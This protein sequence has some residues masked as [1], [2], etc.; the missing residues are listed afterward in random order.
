MLQNLAPIAAAALLSPLLLL[1]RPA[2]AQGNEFVAFAALNA[3]PPGSLVPI[4]IG[5]RVTGPWNVVMRYARVRYPRQVARH[6]G[7]LTLDYGIAGGRGAVTAGVN[8]CDG[9]DPLLNAAFDYERVISTSAQSGGE[10]TVSLKPAIGYGHVMGRE[11]FSILSASLG[12][13]IGLRTTYPGLDV[14]VM[15]YIVPA[16]GGGAFASKLDRADG[17]LRAM[18]GGGLR[19]DWRQR[20]TGLFVG[21]NKVFIE[22]GRMVFGAGVSVNA[23]E[24]T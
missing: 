15:P 18:L 22:D 12:L 21:F 19:F 24:P 4:A 3:T 10:L 11:S 8:H 1:A 23:G 16:I 7:G 17:G 14:S 13:P 2:L 5:S 9:C 6:H 20:Q